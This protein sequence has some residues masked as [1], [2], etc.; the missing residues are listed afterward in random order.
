MK[1]ATIIL[2]LFIFSCGQKEPIPFQQIGKEYKTLRKVLAN[3]EK[4]QV[5]IL[6][7][8]IDRDEENKIQ[9]TNYDLGLDDQKYFYPASTIKLPVAIL[10]LEWL[11]EQNID[12]LTAESIMLTDSIRILQSAVK[13]DS[14]AHNFLPNIAHYIKKILLVSDNDAYNRLYELL[15]QDYINTKLLSKGLSNTIINHRLSIAMSPEE[16]RHFN[17]IHFHDIAGKVLLDL[18]ARFTENVYYNQ[19]APHLG[20]AYYSNGELIME[21]MDFTYKNRFSISDF[22]GVIQRIVFPELFK[23]EQRFHIS[24]TDREFILAYMSMLPKESDYPKYEITE[25]YDSFSKFYKFGTSQDPIPSNFKIFNKTGQ[26][27]GHLLDGSYFTDKK[28]GVEFFVSA[29]IYVNENQTLNDNQYEY[30]EI[31]FPFYEELGNYLYDLEIK[32]RK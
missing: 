11:R 20:G 23:E 29:I 26:A 24:E 15:G 30:E 10:A 19:D 17:P 5:Q 21:A 25:Y 9:L 16:N 27:Y 22:H 3:R 13:Y 18:P 2:L 12:G 31:G 28:N 32:R 4:Y 1:N 8:Q 7:T 14:T 6:Y